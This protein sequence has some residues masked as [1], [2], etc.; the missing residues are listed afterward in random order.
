VHRTDDHEDLLD[1][2]SDETFPASDPPSWSAAPT[3]GDER[4]E[5]PGTRERH[6][7]GRVV[8]EG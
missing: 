3:V 8:E 4:P 5:P 7:L 1:E 6:G 2:A